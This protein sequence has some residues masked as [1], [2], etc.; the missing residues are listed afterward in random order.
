[1]KDY[2]KKFLS[3][4]L[5]MAMLIPSVQYAVPVFAVTVEP[6]IRIDYNGHT[7]GVYY[8]TLSFDDAIAYC[9][10]QGGHLA[11]I[12]SQ[13]ENDAIASM[14]SGTDKSYWIG[15]ESYNDVWKLGRN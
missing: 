12:T 13:G 15:A 1:M 14:L 4:L 2:A 3:I 7:Y 9:E 5:I 8:Q 6:S 11:T 10:A